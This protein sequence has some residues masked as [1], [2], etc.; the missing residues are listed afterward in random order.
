MVLGGIMKKINLIIILLILLCAC[1]KNVQDTNNDL[2]EKVDVEKEPEENSI[3]DAEVDRT[4]ILSGEIITD[5]IYGKSGKYVMYFVPDKETRL[6]LYKDHPLGTGESLMLQFEDI[7]LIKDIPEE[8]GVYKV[9][10]HADFSG[11]WTADLKSIKLTDDIGT[12]EYEGKT[13]ETNDLDENVQPKDSVCGLIVENVRRFDGG[14]VII[15]FAG[16]IESG[17]YYNVYPGGDIFQYNRVG[18]IIVENEYKKN[19][20]TYKGKGNNFS[21]WFTE[22]NE[23]YDE[24][25]EFSAIGRGK[26]KS[27]NYYLVYN[28]GMGA[29]PGEILTEIVSLDENYNGL[30]EYNENEIRIVSFDDDY[31][32]AVENKIEELEIVESTYYFV[33]LGEF[34]KIKIASSDST[35]GYK[36]EKSNED[37]SNKNSSDFKMIS[38]TYGNSVDN[39]E[40][41]HTIGYRFFN[42]NSNSS[43]K[44]YLTKDVNF[45]V[46]K[47]GENTVEVYEGDTFLGMVAEDISVVYRCTEELPEELEKI[48]IKFTGEATFTGKLN[49]STDNEFGYQ[50]FFVADSESISKLPHHIEDT[51]DSAG[52]KFVNENLKEILGEEPFSKDCEVTI[53]NYNIHYAATEASNTAELVTVKFI[54]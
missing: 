49:V 47:D 20:P 2:Q 3:K 32:I 54:E 21:V 22:T 39:P 15:S 14:G 18:E 41:S 37:M 16:E 29:G 35:S 12:V 40:M 42:K 36:F 19:F 50:V 6:Y 7:S 33:A 23:L 26:F 27:S 45:G 52:F 53:K 43:E 11:K 28:Y 10:I 30:F 24:L 8:I 48:R 34:S 5:G 31:L 46:F 38:Q 4:G 17:G 1:T 51:R 9:E 44:E 13:Y 25:A